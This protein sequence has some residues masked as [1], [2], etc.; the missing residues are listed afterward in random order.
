MAARPGRRPLSPFGCDCGVVLG[1][2]CG[3]A[4]FP[5]AALS[6]VASRSDLGACRI[7]GRSAVGGSSGAPV[8]RALPR[9]RDRLLDLDAHGTGYRP[10]E[11]VSLLQPDFLRPV[12]FPWA[13]RPTMRAVKPVCCSVLETEIWPNL[14]REAKRH[15]ASVLLANGRISDKS[16][17][18]YRSLRWFF[19][20]TL[21]Q[22]D[23]VLTQSE[24]DA[25]RFIAAG[26]P[27]D[28]VNA[29]GN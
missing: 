20:P 28:A 6:A 15:G 27:P 22:C 9:A 10:G 12:R 16:E 23:A 5:A 19:A 25:E 1:D 8:A 29:A 26:A 2:A 18:R 17:P 11:A 21:E 14:F 13:V 3:K 7:G 24:Q 4:W